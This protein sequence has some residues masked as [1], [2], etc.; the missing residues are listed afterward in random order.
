MFGPAN[1]V[2]NYLALEI[3]IACCFF[4][5]TFSHKGGW[6]ITGTPGPPLATPPEFKKVA[7]EDVK[8]VQSSFAHSSANSECEMFFS[9]V[10][11]SKRCRLQSGICAILAMHMFFAQ[12]FGCFCHFHKLHRNSCATAPSVVHFCLFLSLFCTEDVNYT[13]IWKRLSNSVN[14]GGLWSIIQGI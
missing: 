1:G 13:D 11:S 2:C 9:V 5:F 8:F 12:C 6:G 14:S 4:G 10:D 7:S 3:F